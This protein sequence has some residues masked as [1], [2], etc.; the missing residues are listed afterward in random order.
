MKTNRKS[1]SA[2]T[3][4]EIM[5]VVAIIGILA[6]IA[7]PGFRKALDDSRRQ[8]CQANLKAIEGAKIAWAAAQR[9]AGSEVPGDADL[10]GPN[11]YIKGKP[12]CPSGGN[13]ELNGLDSDPTCSVPTHTLAAH[14]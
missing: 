7:I 14:P 11:A 3:L 5:V 6:S 2:F 4:I 12:S 13:Y 1:L 8:A 9:K 10:F